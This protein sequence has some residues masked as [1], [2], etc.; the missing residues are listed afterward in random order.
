MNRRNV[1]VLIGGAFA[2]PFIV[3]LALPLE[4]P[5]RIALVALISFPYGFLMGMPFPLG[6]RSSASR[7]DGAPVSALWGINGVASVVG[8]VSAVA[9][10]VVAGF[11][12]VFMLGAACYALAW[13]TRPR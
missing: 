9:L 10:A 4:L 5:L 11:T 1:L 6:L 12:A 2:V 7:S 8:S 3:K 13:A